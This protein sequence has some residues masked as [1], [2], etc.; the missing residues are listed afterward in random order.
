[1]SSSSSSSSS[2]SCCRCNG[3]GRCKNCVCV[4]SKRSCSTCLPSRRGTCQNSKPTVGTTMDCGSSGL[5]SAGDGGAGDGGDGEDSTDSMDS[6]T[7]RRDTQLFAAIQSPLPQPSVAPS[8]Q[9]PTTVPALPPAAGL[10]QANFVWGLGEV[11]SEQFIPSVRVAYSECVHWRRNIFSVPS[12]RVGKAFVS[13]L[14]WLF[15]AYADGSTLESIALTA[16]MLLP[17]LL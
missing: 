7:Q 15:K 4:K 14:A 3:S 5:G 9:I 16:A 17:L 1:M 11:S 13:E 10:A 8:R 12:G 2:S 6:A